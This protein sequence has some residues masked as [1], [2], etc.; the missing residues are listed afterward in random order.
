MFEVKEQGWLTGER[1]YEGR[2]YLM[3]IH[4]MADTCH[5]IHSSNKLNLSVQESGG[6]PTGVTHCQDLGTSSQLRT[7][8]ALGTPCAGNCQ[9]CVTVFCG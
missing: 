2:Y 9:R 4:Y 5:V 6:T 7:Q 8:S 1:I 3:V